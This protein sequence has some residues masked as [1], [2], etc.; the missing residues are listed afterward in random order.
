MYKSIDDFIKKIKKYMMPY[1]KQ[2]QPYIKH[3]ESYL[4]YLKKNKIIIVACIGILSGLIFSCTRGTTPVMPHSE[5]TLPATSP[6]E[7]VISGTGLVEANSENINISAPSSGIVESISVVDGQTV[8]KG[9]VLFTLDQRSLK[10]E[11][12][13]RREE[14]KV[15]E[16]TLESARVNLKDL[17]DQLARSEKLGSGVAISIDQLQRRRFAVEKAKAQVAEA[18]SSLKRSQANLHLT[19]VNLQKLT[20]T[21]PIDGTVLKI[22]TRIGEF[23]SDTKNTSS[24]I[25]MGNMT[26]LYVRIQIDENDGWRFVKGTPA[27]AFLQ[28]NPKMSF[29]LKFIRIDSYAQAKTNLSGDSREVVDTRVIECVYEILGNTESLFIGQQLD[30]FIKANEAP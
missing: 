4:P 21:A 28:S 26:P 13:L 2:L 25:L 20:V 27:K 7:F 11:L 14:S 8:K 15:L 29:D 9:D 1:L 17:E 16:N 19:E 3:V 22:R 24:P 30:V 18:E 6:Y 23:V 5:L 10:A 12:G